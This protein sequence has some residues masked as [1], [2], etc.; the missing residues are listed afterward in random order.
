MQAPPRQA[1]EDCGWGV[2][3]ALEGPEWGRWLWGGRGLGL[4]GAALLRLGRR[5]QLS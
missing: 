1:G 2:R 5:L 4:E 3:F